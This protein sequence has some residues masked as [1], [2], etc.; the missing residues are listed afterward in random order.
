MIREGFDIEIKCAHMSAQE[1]RVDEM[2]RHL[3]A[4]HSLELW[5][6]MSLLADYGRH[7]AECWQEYE[8]WK[9]TTAG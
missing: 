9:T 6:D 3:T 1:G 5:A 4:A 2:A 8:Q 7:D